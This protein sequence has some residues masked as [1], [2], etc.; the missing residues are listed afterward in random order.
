MAALTQTAAN[1]ALGGTAVLFQKVQ[2]GE[3]LT[4]GNAV[5]LKTSDSKYW[6]TDA[7]AAAS[8]VL[9]GVAITPAAADG[10]FILQTAGPINLGGT[11]AVGVDYYIHTT[12]GA[13]GLIGELT[14][15]DFASR[16]GKAIT[17]S[18][19]QLDIDTATVAIA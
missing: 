15:G 14:T 10:Y 16:L 17:T 13:I 6:K 7:D 8:S 9:A 4:Q 1:V 5:Y 18:V 11:L 19:L 3:I 2:A 12:A